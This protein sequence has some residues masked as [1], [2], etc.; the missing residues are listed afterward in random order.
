MRVSILESGNG[1]VA[2]IQT[3]YSEPA[4]NLRSDFIESIP[5][6]QKLRDKSALHV[7]SITGQPL[8]ACDDSR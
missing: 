8:G 2:A 5:E 1:P 7:L 6:M 3:G 4:S